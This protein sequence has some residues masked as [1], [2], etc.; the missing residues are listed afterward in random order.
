MERKNLNKYIIFFIAIMALNVFVMMIVAALINMN[1]YGD[2]IT[3]NEKK[4]GFGLY[5][6]LFPF[7]F[8]YAYKKILPFL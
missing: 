7:V 8:Y 2:Y 3:W 6:I 5:L 4:N 1:G